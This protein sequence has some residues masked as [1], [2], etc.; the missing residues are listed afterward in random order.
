MEGADRKPG[1]RHLEDPQQVVEPVRLLA[2]HGGQG[3]QPVVP[4]PDEQRCDGL[5]HVQALCGDTGGSRGDT[6]VHGGT[7]GDTKV[8]E[9]T[10]GVTKVHEGPQGDTGGHEGTRGDTGGHEGTRGD[11]GGH[12]G[13]RRYTGGHRGSR[14]DTGGHGGPGKTDMKE[15]SGFP[16]L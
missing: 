1:V 7:Q 9:G 5:V 6:K 11:T 15:H 8:H 2:Q 10:Q 4:I 16:G 13:S 12:R 14:G 3:V